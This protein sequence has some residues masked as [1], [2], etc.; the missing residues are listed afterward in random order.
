MLFPVILGFGSIVSTVCSGKIALDGGISLIV[1]FDLLGL[2]VGEL[3]KGGSIDGSGGVFWN[4]VFN[5]WV[6]IVQVLFVVEF[7]GVVDFSVDIDQIVVRSDDVEFDGFCGV[8]GGGSLVLSVEFD[9]SAFF[10]D[11]SNGTSLLFL[12]DE[13]GERDVEIYVGVL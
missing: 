12:S 9:F 8:S 11:G 7:G 10:L 5:N 13:R 2:D 3:V 1:K 6:K 4:P